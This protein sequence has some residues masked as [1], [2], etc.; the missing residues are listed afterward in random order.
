ME[1]NAI[2]QQA[3][4]LVS[5]WAKETKTPEPNRLDVSIAPG[6]LLSAVS[7]LNQ[8]HW[9]FLSAITGLDLTPAPPANKATE[10]PAPGDLEVLYHFCQGQ[11]VATLRVR[12][13]RQDPTL[14][15]VCG[16]IPY[17]SLSERELGEMFG[18]TLTGVEY[19]PHMFLSEDWPA[20]VYPLRKDFQTHANN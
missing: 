6:D 11:A 7:A 5:P 17:V 19:P 3:T 9:G 16:I 15:S 2:L 10:P 12:L 8:A 4:E 13:P 14:P 20:G 18:I 1:T